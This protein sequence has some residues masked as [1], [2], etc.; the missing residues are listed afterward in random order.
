MIKLFVFLGNPGE[1]YKNTRHNAGFLLAEALYPN[2]DWQ[3]KFHS[4]FLSDGKRK[5]LKPM[6]YMNLSGTAVSEAASFFKLKSDEIIVIH[7][8]TELPFGKIKIQKGGGLQGHKGLKSI[9]ERLGN[10]GFYR[11]RIG[12]GKPRHGDLAL[13]VTTPFTKDEMISLSLLFD[14]AKTLLETPEIANERLID[15]SKSSI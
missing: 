7:D 6:T 4:A 9:K 2:A 3:M 5:I 8:D 1:Q 14:F 10:D 11:L 13:Y 15:T 12:I